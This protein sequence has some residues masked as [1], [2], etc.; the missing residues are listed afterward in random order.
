MKFYYVIF[1][2]GPLGKV[3]FDSSKKKIYLESELE[4]RATAEDYIVF[5]LGLEPNQCTIK[6][7]SKNHY[8]KIKTSIK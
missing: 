2:R 5:G 6:V 1:E 8:E 3:I 4:A 7:L